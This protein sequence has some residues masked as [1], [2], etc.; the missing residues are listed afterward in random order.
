MKPSRKCAIC[1]ASGIL[2]KNHSFFLERLIHT[3]CKN[4]IF[5]KSAYVMILGI[6]GTI[7]STVDVFRMMNHKRIDNDTSD[8]HKNCR[9]SSMFARD[10]KLMISILGIEHYVLLVL[11]TV[12]EV[13][14]L[15]MQWLLIHAFIIILEIGTIF[16]GVVFK[17]NTR[18]DGIL[19][20]ILA[21]FNW[22]QVFCYFLKQ[23]KN[24]C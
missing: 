24:N 20:T 2:E 12:M 21:T 1:Q 10:L 4:C 7:I 18:F 9:V 5:G 14:I 8:Q 22:L 3:V 16:L 13:P 15:H 19:E 23:L 6:I 11:G 17:L